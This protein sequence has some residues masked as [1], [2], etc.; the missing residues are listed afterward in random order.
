KKANENAQEAKDNEKKANDNAQE[1]KDNKQEAK[2]NEKLATYRLGV[3]HMLL[4]EEAYGKGNVTLAAAYLEKVPKDQRGWEWHYKKQE[5][6]GGL[7]T[8]Y[9][10][11]WGFT[12]VAFSP[13]GTRILTGGGDSEHPGEVRVWDARTGEFLFELKGVPAL[14]GGPT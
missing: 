3:N 13:D 5:T 4:A 8:I 7:F 12:S 1:A 6:R 14:N 9:G 10:D 11:P 2:D